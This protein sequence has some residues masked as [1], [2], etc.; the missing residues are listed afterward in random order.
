[1]AKVGRSRTARGDSPRRKIGLDMAGK[2]RSL[3]VL[4]EG[5][6]PILGF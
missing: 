6:L 3:V 1:M 2:S 5:V 4:A